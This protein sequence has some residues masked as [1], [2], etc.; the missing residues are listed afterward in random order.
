MTK[1]IIT[2]A[3]TLSLPLYAYD[4]HE[5]GTFTTVSGSD[6]VYLS[7]LH[8]EEEHLPNFVY[9]HAGLNN[10]FA[11][12]YSINS[13]N[14]YSYPTVI[15]PFPQGLTASLNSNSNQLEVNFNEKTKLYDMGRLKIPAT[16]FKGMPFEK[17]RDL[18]NV[19]VKMETPVIYFYN[20][21]GEKINIKVGFNGG[22]ISQWYPN[23]TN[24]DTPNQI[25][26]TDE[27][28]SPQL[29]S[30]LTNNKSNVSIVDSKP[31]DFGK[32]YQ[33]SIEWDLELLNADD[34]YTFKPT[35]NKTWIYPRVSGTNMVKVGDEYE[36]YLFYRGIG[37]FKLPVTFTVDQDETVH[38]K[39][40]SSEAIPFAFAYEK[41]GNI[42]K[43]K[44]LGEV[45][46][47]A[48]IPQQEWTT[49]KSNWQTEIFSEM[50]NGLAAQG[51]T[52]DEANGMVKT[53][54]K[55][56]FQQDGL[57]V[58]WVV[59]QNELDKILPLTA[60]PKP[61]KSFFAAYKNRL[62][63]IITEPVYQNISEEELLYS[64]INISAYKTPKDK[65]KK[66]DLTTQLK[67]QA[68][69]LAE[70]QPYFVS[71][72]FLKDQE[73]NLGDIGK[74]KNWKAINQ[75][76]LMIGELHFK[77]DRTTG[78][79]TAKVDKE[80]MPNCKYDHLEIKLIKHLN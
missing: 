43:Y 28:M 4:L 69:T 41:T 25:K 8:I 24:G 70:Q 79:M 11:N 76:E 30:H 20:G 37:N 50:R 77:L 36:D 45:K 46:D 10:L 58:F 16:S 73:I 55:S 18:K 80:K 34:A 15:P 61:E 44:V 22:T 19:T 52:T 12:T 47:S 14:S 23:R 51:L 65:I 35:Q 33:G 64:Y 6:G 40:K 72:R 49:A 66:I 68:L 53:W 60:T 62:E 38:V 75:D 74:F 5:W 2:L 78:I 42:V 71:V 21:A 56:Y 1:T 63:A 67:Q 39:N 54:W 13:Y 26:L 3:A 31:L 7:G 48:S 57:R 32:N 17:P 27:Q 29:K 59:P 9:S